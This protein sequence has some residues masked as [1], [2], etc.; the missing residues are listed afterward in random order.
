MLPA[1]P[2]LVH[3]Y[4]TPG[5]YQRLLDRH[6]RVLQPLEQ[7]PV[8]GVSEPVVRVCLGPPQFGGLLHEV[9][10]DVL[11][12][13]LGDVLGVSWS[14]LRQ[15]N[16]LPQN[17]PIG[18][19]HTLVRACLSTRPARASP[20]PSPRGARSVCPRLRRGCSGARTPAPRALLLEFV[21]ALA[22]SPAEH[23]PPPGFLYALLSPSRSRARLCL[24]RSSPPLSGDSRASEGASM[25]GMRSTS[26]AMILRASAW[27]WRSACSCSR[28]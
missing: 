26:P 18:P 28:R 7:D 15:P 4:P 20:S 22:H 9:V 23:P 27:A 2:L 5:L 17:R 14:H 24:S 19:G 21:P 13:I 10:E 1:R 16:P 8:L 6:V 11:G 25:A 12:D 3:P